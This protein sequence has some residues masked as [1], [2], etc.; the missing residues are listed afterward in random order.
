MVEIGSLPACLCPESYSEQLADPVKPM[1]EIASLP[2]CLCPESYSE[3][4]IRSN[5]WLREQFLSDSIT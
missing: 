1:V 2:A 5:Q 4:L 3:Q